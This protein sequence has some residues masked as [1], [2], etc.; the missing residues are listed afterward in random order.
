MG[1]VEGQAQS[2]DWYIFKIFK[3]YFLLFLKSMHIFIYLAVSASVAARS[4]G[5][6]GAQTP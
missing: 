2:S 4:L 5:S 1:Q 3:C 6:R